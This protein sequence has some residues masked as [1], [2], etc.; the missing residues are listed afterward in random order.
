M[1]TC[2]S[3]TAHPGNRYGTAH[4]ALQPMEVYSSAE[5]ADE[6]QIESHDEC[7]GAASVSIV[8]RDK[9]TGFRMRRVTST[10]HKLLQPRSTTYRSKTVP[11]HHLFTPCGPHR[12]PFASYCKHPSAFLSR[13][14]APAAAILHKELHVTRRGLAGNS[15]STISTHAPHDSSQYT[16]QPKTVQSTR[17]VIQRSFR[18]CWAACHQRCPASCWR[19]Q[20]RRRCHPLPRRSR[21]STERRSR[22]AEDHT[23]PAAGTAEGHRSSEREAAARS[24]LPA[25]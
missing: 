13:T 20:P 6:V 11:T 23:V 1:Q 15:Q 12:T 3:M 10:D 18:T 9:A 25:G 19:A 22:P 4:T 21:P 7:E 5:K 16:P 17:K 8:A 14:A 24:G 2:T